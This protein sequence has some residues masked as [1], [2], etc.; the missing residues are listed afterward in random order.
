[1]I[2]VINGDLLDAKEQYIAHQC[3]CVTTKSKGLSKL[4]FDKYPTTDI[5]SNRKKKKDI[6]GEIKVFNSKNKTIINI[7]AQY[8]PGPSNY[9]NDSK[10]N[11]KL[12]FK[13][14]LE[15]ISE[16]PGIENGLALP[17]NIGCGLAGGN[18]DEYYEIIKQ[19]SNKYFI[20][21]TLYKL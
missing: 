2:K 16:L 20:P 10:Q 12:W 6:P 19:F 17:Y 18:W 8:Y 3:N 5:Y 7:L 4:I 13:K 15:L 9:E 14:C 11:R 21:V 1:M